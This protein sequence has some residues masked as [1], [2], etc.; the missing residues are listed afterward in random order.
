LRQPWCYWDNASSTEDIVREQQTAQIIPFPRDR[1][2]APQTPAAALPLTASL[3]GLLAALEKQR[4]SVEK[5]RSAM[6]DLSESMKGL[7][8]NLGQFTLPPPEK[9]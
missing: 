9:G 8:I 6:Q 3:A 4:A 1:R 2:A 5:W 7:S